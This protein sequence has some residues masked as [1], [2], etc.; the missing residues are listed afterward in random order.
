[1]PARTNAYGNPECNRT[2]SVG[3]FQQALAAGVLHLAKKYNVRPR[4]K[5]IQIRGLVHVQVSFLTISKEELYDVVILCP[6]PCMLQG[7]PSK[8][9]VAKNGSASIGTGIGSTGAKAHPPPAGKS[10]FARL[11]PDSEDVILKPT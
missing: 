1:M 11:T 5:A 4:H 3:L 9:L 8:A 10:L 2:R 7:Y 6:S